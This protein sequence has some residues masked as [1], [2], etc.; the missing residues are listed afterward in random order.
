M[1]SS[2]NIDLQRDFA[3]GVYMSEAQ[4]SI[5]P[6]LLQWIRVYRGGSFKE[7]ELSRLS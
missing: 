3:A 7:I 1:S 5:P 2:E 4:N 6:P